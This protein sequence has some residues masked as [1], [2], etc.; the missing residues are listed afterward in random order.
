MHLRLYSTSDLLLP[1]DDAAG[2]SQLQG[3]SFASAIVVV[4][5]QSQRANHLNCCLNWCRKYLSVTDGG[6]KELHYVLPNDVLP[7]DTMH[8]IRRATRDWTI[9]IHH[10]RRRCTPESHWREFLCQR[11]A[12]TNRG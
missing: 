10:P 1:S 11:V 5:V 3:L 9:V 6:A 7:D 2:G 8:Q 4:C 12:T